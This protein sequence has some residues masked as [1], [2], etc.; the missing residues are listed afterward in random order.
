MTDG[1]G[2]GALSERERLAIRRALRARDAGAQGRIARLGRVLMHPRHE[3]GDVRR[4]RFGI[5]MVGFAIFQMVLVAILPNDDRRWVFFG[6]AWLTLF[7]GAWQIDK[8]RPKA[9]DK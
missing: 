4:Y 5:A 2:N 9:S 7:V 3:Q 6:F 1:R 8:S